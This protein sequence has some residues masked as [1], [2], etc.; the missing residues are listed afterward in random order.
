MINLINL[1]SSLFPLHNVIF[2]LLSRNNIVIYFE[3]QKTKKKKQKK[4]EKKKKK[5]K[6][7][8]KEYMKYFHD[9]IVDSIQVCIDP[10]FDKKLLKEFLK[11]KDGDSKIR[12]EGVHARKLSTTILVTKQRLC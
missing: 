7:K 1:P 8:K 11:I 10:D 2:V 12:G 5:E 6:E 9:V 4:K 3:K